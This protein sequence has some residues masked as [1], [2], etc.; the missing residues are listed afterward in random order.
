MTEGRPG[1]LVIGDAGLANKEAEG[2]L[3][4]K[5]QYERCMYD[6]KRVAKSVRR[7][8]LVLEGAK[9][10]NLGLSSRYPHGNWVSRREGTLPKRLSIQKSSQIC[11]CTDTIKS[12]STYSM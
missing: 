6:D 12:L 10:P 4:L 11:L 8:L 7:D 3:A 9:I 2:W 5:P 1:Q